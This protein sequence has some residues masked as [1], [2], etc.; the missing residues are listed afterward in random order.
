MTF[1]YSML[2]RIRFWIAW[3]VPWLLAW[4]VWANEAV[5]PLP[6]NPKEWWFKWIASRLPRT[7]KRCMLERVAVVRHW[8][9]KRDQ[10]W[11]D[12]LHAKS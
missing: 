12:V 3:K 6:M 8:R 5:D 2:F 9:L 7:L 11:H 1:R 10:R 4:F